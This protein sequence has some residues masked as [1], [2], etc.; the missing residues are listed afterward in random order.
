LYGVLESTLRDRHLGLQPVALEN[1]PLP[2]LGP[3]PNFT[4]AEEKLLVD[5]ISYM[6]EIGYGYTR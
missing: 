2:N 4:E 1:E 3:K 5:H 6:A